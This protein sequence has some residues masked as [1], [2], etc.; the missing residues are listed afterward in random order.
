MNVI[1]WIIAIVLASLVYPILAVFGVWV[2]HVLFFVLLVFGFKSL[3]D[4]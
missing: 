1:K 4:C 3:L 2:L